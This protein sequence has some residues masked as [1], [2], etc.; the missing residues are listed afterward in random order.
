LGVCFSNEDTTRSKKKINS[1]SS[2][3]VEIFKYA[4]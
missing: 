4:R 1:R 3:N 2:V